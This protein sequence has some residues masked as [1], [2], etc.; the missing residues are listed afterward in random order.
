MESILT[1]RILTAA[2]KYVLDKMKSSS[3]TAK[4][5]GQQN[6]RKVRRVISV[7]LDYL[8][9]LLLKNNFSCPNTG[10]KFPMFNTAQEYKEAATK[11]IIN[12]L[13][14]P[15]GDRINSDLDYVEGN[16]EI[17]TLFY[18]NGKGN[19]TKE[20]ALEILNI[21]TKTMSSKPQT[22]SNELLIHFAE[23]GRFD[24]CE[25]YFTPP[26]VESNKVKVTAVSS[27]YS[28]HKNKRAKFD[29]LVV[30]VNDVLD[31]KCIS[32]DYDTVKALVASKEATQ[33]IE[34]NTT[35]YALPK[36]GSRGFT[37]YIDK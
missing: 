14:L 27:T 1:D 35:I 22:F 29:K 13:S 30:N 7:D 16:I 21:K 36:Q 37:Y 15:S 5:K 4:E 17:T 32:D 28:Y 26:N 10:V 20:Q 6:G 19:K 23:L 31:K 11:K 18:N 9:A 33:L 2:A 25:Q 8:K 24:L 12:P 34:S 3:R